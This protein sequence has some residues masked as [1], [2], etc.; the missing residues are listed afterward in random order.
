MGKKSVGEPRIRLQL[1]NTILTVPQID[2][3]KNIIG[4]SGNYNSGEDNMP[5]TVTYDVEF[6]DQV[7][8][9]LCEWRI[10]TRKV[11]AK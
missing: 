5:P 4:A 8:K 3:I 1:L 6:H 9:K 2:E 10:A 11:A 7:M